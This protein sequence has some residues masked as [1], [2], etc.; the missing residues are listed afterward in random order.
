M[1]IFLKARFGTVTNATKEYGNKSTNYFQPYF[2]STSVP[3]GEL[4][5]QFSDWGCNINW[6]LKGEGAMMKEE[7][8]TRIEQE[9]NSYARQRMM[10]SVQPN[11]A[12]ARAGIPQTIDNPPDEVVIAKEFITVNEYSVMVVTPE[13]KRVLFVKTKE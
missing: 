10:A 5:A 3:G 11:F 6:L 7:E 2:K 4:L 8:E 13:G 1:K 12:S 9:H